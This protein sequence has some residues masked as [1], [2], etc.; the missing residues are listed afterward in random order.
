[1]KIIKYTWT[2]LLLAAASLCGKTD[3]NATVDINSTKP[4]IINFID[5][6]MM[7]RQFAYTKRVKENVALV[8]VADWCQASRHLLANVKAFEKR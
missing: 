1:M 4:K 2:S 8:F 3:T 7:D 6:N 5:M